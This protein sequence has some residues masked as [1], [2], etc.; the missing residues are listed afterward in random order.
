VAFLASAVSPAVASAAASAAL[1][2]LAEEKEADTT[3]SSSSSSDSK[4]GGANVDDGKRATKIRIKLKDEHGGVETTSMDQS[5]DGPPATAKPVEVST[6]IG[7]GIAI[8][9][10]NPPFNETS[11]SSPSSS[12]TVESASPPASR[13]IDGIMIR[14]DDIVEVNLPY[15]KGYM[16]RSGVTRVYFAAL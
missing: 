10:E 2:A 1:R 11:P 7:N 8:I 3:S 9:P 13:T 4:T 6:P 12:A 5:N 15:G 14:S 16:H